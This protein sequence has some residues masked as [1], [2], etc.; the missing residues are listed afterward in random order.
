VV[1]GVGCVC[2]GG[3]CMNQSRLVSKNASIFTL[4]SYI[5]ASSFRIGFVHWFRKKLDF[6]HW[7]RTLVSKFFSENRRFM[8]GPK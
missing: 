1:V 5:G 4:V 2:G 8:I 3:V 6:S 7:F